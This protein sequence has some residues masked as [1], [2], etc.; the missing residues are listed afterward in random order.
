MPAKTSSCTPAGEK[1][2][3]QHVDD[4]PLAF[5]LKQ[6]FLKP[7]TRTLVE[8]LKH[9][10]VISSTCI[11]FRVSHIIVEVT[12][13]ND[14]LGKFPAAK[15]FYDD[16]IIVIAVIYLVSSEISLICPFLL[17]CG[18][19]ITIAIRRKLRERLKNW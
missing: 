1:P 13:G 12:V 10:F 17:S 5:W 7:V 11:F 4:I 15:V 8:L 18:K 6:H 14:I 19:D 2:S 3:G 9:L 16:C